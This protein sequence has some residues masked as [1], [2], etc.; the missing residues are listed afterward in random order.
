MLVTLV[1]MRAADPEPRY[2]S[3]A[4]TARY[5]QLTGVRVEEGAGDRP[6]QR[7]R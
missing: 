5:T 7:T 6:A 1:A 2:G 4:A 3:L